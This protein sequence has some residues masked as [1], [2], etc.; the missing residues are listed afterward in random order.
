M[1]NFIVYIGVGSKKSS[2]ASAGDTEKELYNLD[3]ESKLHKLLWKSLNLTS[4]KNIKQ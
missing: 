3:N 2:L 1:A 4:A